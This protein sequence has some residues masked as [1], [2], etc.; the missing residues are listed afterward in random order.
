[1]VDE[2]PELIRKLSKK[3]IRVIRDKEK[4]TKLGEKLRTL[5]ERSTFHGIDVLLEASPGWRRRTVLIILIIMCFACILNVSHLIAGF[6]NMPVSTVINDEKA[7]FTFPIVAICPDSPFSIERVSQDEE[8]RNACL[9]LANAARALQIRAFTSSVTLQSE[10]IQLPRYLGSADFWIARSGDRDTNWALPEGY[11]RQRVK[12]SFRG[13][14]YTNRSRLSWTWNDILVSCEYDGRTC[15]LD[16]HA[17]EA[18][19]AVMPI[20]EERHW[21][22]KYEYP[23][24][25]SRVSNV[26]SNL[27]SGWSREMPDPLKML[28]KTEPWPKGKVVILDHPSK[29]YCFQS[30]DDRLFLRQPQS[31][32]SRR[33][34]RQAVAADGFHILISRAAKNEE[35]GSFSTDDIYKT[36]S[37]RSAARFG[38]RY[39]QSISVSLN[40]FVH[41]RLTS[42]YRPCKRRFPKENYLELSS[43]IM[44]GGFARRYFELSYTKSNCVAYYRQKVMYR[45]CRCFSEDYMVPLRMASELLKLG[46]CH[47]PSPGVEPGSDL[48]MRRVACHDSVASM[49]GD[50]ILSLNFPKS[51][52]VALVIRLTD[53][54]QRYWLCGRYCE[55]VVSEADIIQRHEIPTDLPPSLTGFSNITKKSDLVAI[56]IYANAARVRVISEGEQANIFNLIASIGGTF[57]LYLGLSGVTLFEIIEAL[58]LLLITTPALCRMNAR[59]IR[60]RRRA[61]VIRNLAVERLVDWKSSA[62]KKNVNAAT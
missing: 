40:Q 25:V 50:E 1:M 48:F 13:F 7:N 14:F 22:S 27:P 19:T 18:P 4:V 12:R 62:A 39:G 36:S 34:A 5:G 16:E 15:E 6:V 38:V 42:V 57:G 11:W 23:R 43:Y 20:Q 54:I 44:S 35:D 49:T 61:R 29:Y 55:E 58:A 2:R 10:L 31:Q 8:L 3:D 47:S 59:R 26:E 56:T 52:K 30:W 28:E 21:E 33:D 32:A 51:W 45:L 60:M 41:K 17:V 53:E 37:S 24:L 9:K 46:F